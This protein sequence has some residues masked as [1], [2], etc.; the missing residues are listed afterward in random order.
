MVRGDSF[1]AVSFDL[2]IESGSL[3]YFRDSVEFR[4][5]SGRTVR[6]GLYFTDSSILLDSWVQYQPIPQEGE[7]YRC[8][9]LEEY[10]LIEYK[11]GMTKEAGGMVAIIQM[12]HH[13]ERLRIRLNDVYKEVE[14][15]WPFLEPG[16]SRRKYEP[17]VL[18]GKG[19][20]VKELNQVLL[21]I[22]KANI[23]KAFLV[24]S[25]QKY[26]LWEG[27]PVRVGGLWS[28]KG[29]PYFSEDDP[30]QWFF[31][32]NRKNHTGKRTE[33]FISPGQESFPKH[34]DPSYPVWVQ[35]SENT[36]MRTYL[37]VMMEIDGL[38]KQG[39]SIFDGVVPD[40]MFH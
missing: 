33:V 15:I 14:D 2:F 26:F 17:V 39:Y 9:G 1:R 25:Q 36:S 40:S 6:A 29:N 16:H 8:Y 37:D 22:Q 13:G 10:P 38:R 27:V 24:T 34:L 5:N 7:E 19:S 35:V 31:R 4:F 28:V 30:N 18:I 23:R 11:T 3:L 21:Q 20:T 12:V 32:L